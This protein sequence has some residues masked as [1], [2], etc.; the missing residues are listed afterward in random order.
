M[1]KFWND[2]LAESWL[3]LFSLIVP[4]FTTGPLRTRVPSV[5]V[6]VPLLVNS[7]VT[8]P[9]PV[10]EAPAAIS[11]LAA[12]RLPPA[13][14][15]EAALFT[16]APAEQAITPDI[17]GGGL[18]AAGLAAAQFRVQTTRD[19]AEVDGNVAIAVV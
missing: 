18:A 9:L 4:L 7:P 14:V 15:R 11:K 6:I 13:R 2:P 5:P 17:G 19:R 16:S 8:A 3:P 12:V 10:R 1:P